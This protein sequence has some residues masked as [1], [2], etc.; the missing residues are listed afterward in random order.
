MIRER[1]KALLVSV[2]ITEAL[3]IK[4]IYLP[5]NLQVARCAYTLKGGWFWPFI[6][7]INRLDYAN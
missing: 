2:L 5:I 1:L 4:Q 6:C 3:G 7:L